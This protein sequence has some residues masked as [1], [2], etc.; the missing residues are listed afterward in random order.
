MQYARTT[1]KLWFTAMN[2]DLHRLVESAAEM[3][4]ARLAVTLGLHSGEISQR[5]A[6][7]TYGSW[8]ALAL[9]DGKIR[10]IR[11]EEGHAGTRFYRVTDILELKT[12]QSAQAYILNSH[13][14]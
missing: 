13:T 11:I 9:R 1:I 8:F 4:A 5:Q 3:G 10:P 7:K 14:L 2:K 6:L 12:E